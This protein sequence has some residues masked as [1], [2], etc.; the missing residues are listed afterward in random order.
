MIATHMQKTYSVA[1]TVGPASM[2]IFNLRL[3]VSMGSNIMILVAGIVLS[4]FLQQNSKAQ[5][6]AGLWIS[7]SASISY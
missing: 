4:P 7:V 3:P 5:N 6:S 1:L 2:S